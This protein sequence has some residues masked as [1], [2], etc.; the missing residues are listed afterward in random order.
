MAEKLFDAEQRVMGV[1][2]RE[3]VVPA[4]RVAQILG[5]EVGWNKNTTYT[6]IRRCIGKGAIRREEPGFLCHALV[7]REEVQRAE[8]D[9]LIDRV[10]DGCAGGLFASLL[11]SGRLSGEELDQLRRMIDE[12][13]KGE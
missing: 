13:E 8:T 4:R 5:E 9:A 3:G 11:G 10:F 6:L 2:W 1:L 12:A 7:S